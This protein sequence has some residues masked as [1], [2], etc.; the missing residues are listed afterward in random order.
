MWTLDTNIEVDAA[1]RIAR[2]LASIVYFMDVVMMVVDHGLDFEATKDGYHVHRKNRSIGF[3]ASLTRGQPV[4]V[5][6]MLFHLLI[7]DRALVVQSAMY[8]WS[9]AVR[10]RQDVVRGRRLSVSEQAVL[11]VSTYFDD[12]CGY[13]PL[14]SAALKAGHPALQTV[15][16]I[17]TRTL[18]RAFRRLSF[19]DQ[20]IERVIETP[21]VIDTTTPFFDKF[22]VAMRDAS[23]QYGVVRLDDDGLAVRTGPCGHANDTNAGV[24]FVLDKHR[25][26][27]VT[28]RDKLLVLL[29]MMF[30]T[31]VFIIPSVIGNPDAGPLAAGVPAPVSRFIIQANTRRA[32]PFYYG[33][34]DSEPVDEWE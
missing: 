29:L 12:L 3:P 20:E 32:T 19:L 26:V 10:L 30:S 33:R 27:V 14:F 17:A 15:V 25:G 13:H 31:D 5:P 22:S 9:T 23:V 11:Y 7:A 16:S 2:H 34:D 18:R 4:C 21:W 8:T 6:V 28:S 1:I 24:S